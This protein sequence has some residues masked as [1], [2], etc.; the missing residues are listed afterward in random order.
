MVGGFEQAVL[1]AMIFVIMLGMGAALTPRDFALAIKRPYA[2]LIGLVSQY[3]FLPLI[4]LGLALALPVADP[5][6]IGIV[7]M[8]CMPGGTTSNIFTYFA[9]GNLA[10]S[11]LMT[12]NSTIVGVIAIPIL[13]VASLAVLT[14]T[15]NLEVVVPTQNIVLTLVLLLAPVLIGL[16]L[17]KWN[18]NVGALVELVGG[19]L[20]IIFI[21]LL[22]VTWVPRNWGFLTETPPVVFLGVIS[23]GLLGFLAGYLFSMALKL[24]RWNAQ[25]IAMEVGIQNGP[26]AIAIVVFT[27]VGPLA[28]LQ[29]Q[30]L[31]VPALYSLF[32][33]ISATMLTLWFR[34]TNA[35]DDQ[36]MPNA[37]L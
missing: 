10:L 34:R 12:I 13:V 4:G 24:G 37:L 33:V 22:L 8:S 11:V 1:A 31:A 17:R 30:V 21:V 18:A 3:G 16:A 27:F 20:G 32:I 9:K 28:P 26:L 19:A 7:V 2:M 23:L 25:T 15:G 29:Q 36:K 14:A 35:A 6:K 5:V